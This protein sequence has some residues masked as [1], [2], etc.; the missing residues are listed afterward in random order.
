MRAVNGHSDV[1]NQ[2]KV[3]TPVRDEHFL[4]MSA[5]THKTRAHL[6][7]GII[8]SGILPGG[9]YVAPGARE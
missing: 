4:L 8:K 2:D 3:A 5:I 1:I 7:P 6:L 9:V